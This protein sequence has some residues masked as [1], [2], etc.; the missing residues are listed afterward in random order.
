MRVVIVVVVNPFVDGD[1][2]VKRMI[3]VVTPDDV[4]FDGAHNAF[5]VGIALGIAPGGKDLLEAQDRARLH[6]ALGSGLAAVVRD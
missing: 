2:K 4:F 3:P 6:E 5:G 1:F